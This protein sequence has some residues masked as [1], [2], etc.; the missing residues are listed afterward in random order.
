MFM[1]NADTDCLQLEEGCDHMV[2]LGTRIRDLRLDKR[3][4]Q[5]EMSRRIGVSK[6]MI[7]SYE[8]ESRAPSYE[9][10]VKIAAFFNVST[11]YLLGLNKSRTVN[12]DGLSGEEVSAVTHIVE[13][14][15]NK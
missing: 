15:R 10:L 5:T 7:S 13:L 2:N 3:I 14:M 9:I 4:T 11:D 1:P 6:A 8:L 12:C